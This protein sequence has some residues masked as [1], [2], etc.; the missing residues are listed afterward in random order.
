MIASNINDVLNHLDDII[1][2]ARRNKSRRGYFAVLYKQVTSQVQQG[3]EDGRFENGDRMDHLDTAFAN[4]YFEAMKQYEQG[5]KPSKCWAIAFKAEDRGNQTI[6][7]HLL[8][9]MNAHIN[10]DLGI[11]AARIQ[12]T[13]L[14]DLSHDFNTINEILA[15]M[16]DK[17]QHTIN[18]LSPIF[19]LIDTLGGRTDELIANFGIEKARNDAWQFAKQLS[20]QDEPAQ[21]QTIYTIDNKIAL[22]GRL[23]AEPGG[24]VGAGLHLI[25]LFEST[26]VPEVI[27]ALNTIEP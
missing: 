18:R 25:R 11:A 17:V 27:D 3:I 12:P 15:A 6:L 9:A 23:I 7:Q 20:N 2:T 5:K 26:D 1:E 10:L 13:N 21:S 24:L 22:L 14:D 4:R 16:L 8:M 19:G